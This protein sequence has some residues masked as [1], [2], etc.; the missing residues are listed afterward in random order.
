[1]GKRQKTRAEI[2]G[3]RAE[4]WASL[5]LRL[6]GYSIMAT[7][8]KTPFGEID[9]IARKGRTLVFVEV[10][11]RQNPKALPASLTPKAQN[12]I[13]KAA[14]YYVSRNTR[15]QSLVQRFDLVLMSPRGIFSYGNIQ[16]MRDAWR[17]Y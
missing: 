2:S 10:K 6:K 4:R 13:T 16:H 14:T 12:R 1:M 7:R 17:P 11:Y 15:F 5:C 9:I 8:V 3:R